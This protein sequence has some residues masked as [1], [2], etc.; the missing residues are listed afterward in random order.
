MKTYIKTLC[1]SGMAMTL[2]FVNAWGQKKATGI[3]ANTYKA[4]R[5]HKSVEYNLSGKFKYYSSP[6]TLVYSGKNFISRATDDSTFG[7]YLWLSTNDNEYKF[8]D[9]SKIFYVDKN[10]KTATTYDPKKKELFIIN[11][12]I[13]TDEARWKF[14]LNPEKIKDLMNSATA[15]ELQRD[16]MIDGIKCYTI[17]VKSP[18]DH[19]FTDFRQTLFINMKDNIP[20]LTIGTVKFQ[21]SYQ[22]R[23]FGLTS[24]K[25]D[26]VPMS[27]F[28]A[29]QIPANYTM[30]AYQPGKKEKNLS[31]GVP[32][33]VVSGLNFKNNSQQETIDFKGKIT[34]LDFWY[35]TCYPCIKAIPQIEKIAA[36]YK[37]KGV[38]VFGVNSKDNNEAAL[39]RLPDF[40]K[41]NTINYPFLMVDESVTTAY[42]PIAFP[43][44]YII[45]KDGKVAFST[46][47]YSEDLYGDLAAE[48]DKLLK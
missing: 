21:G 7:A 14:F 41:H 42:K 35:M 40:L 44:F 6:D 30:I 29:K 39:K 48:I 3:L 18:D 33:P 13:Y 16:T 43:T 27:Q 1:I 2:L 26:K 19:D 37:E 28:S 10:H 46:A 5:S 20:V 25:F 15:M 17:F 9:R 12:N 34:V 47:G 4:L 11:G 45:D 8:Y 22:Y 38:Q 32:A 24:Y 31:Q 23:E 36:H